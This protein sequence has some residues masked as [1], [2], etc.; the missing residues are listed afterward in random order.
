MIRRCLNPDCRREITECN[1]FV[2]ARDYLDFLDGKL[3]AEKVREFCGLC[4]FRF[5]PGSQA[6]NEFVALTDFRKPN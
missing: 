1:G 6:F 2:L 4:H 3:T 5:P